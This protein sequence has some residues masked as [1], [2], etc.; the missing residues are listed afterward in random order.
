MRDKIRFDRSYGMRMSWAHLKSAVI[1]VTNIGVS[2]MLFGQNTPANLQELTHK[3]DQALRANNLAEAEQEY[4]Q[5]LA[6]DPRNSQAWTG[7]GILLYGSGR[8][9]DAGKAL[10]KALDI[11]PASQRAELFLGLSY[12]YLHRCSTAKPILSKY[13]ESEPVGKLQ[14]LTGLALLGCSSGGTDPLPALQ[15]AERLKQLY[16]GDA[17]VLFESAELYTRLWNQSAGELLAKHPDSDRVHQLAG[18]VYEAQNNYDQA[19]R[20]YFLALADN[21]KLLQMHY[22]IGQLYLKQGSPDADEKAMAEFRQENA[23]NPASAVSN[24]AMAEIER[25]KHMLDQAKSLYELAIRLDPDLTEAKVGLA[26]TLLGQ[27]EIDGASRILRALIAEHPENASAHYALML[28]YREQGNMPEANK[29]MSTFRKLQ[30]ANADDFK[31]K[32][33]ALLNA[34]PENKETL[35]K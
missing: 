10:Q 25:H 6:Q 35:Q 12:S 9:E 1:V 8:A 23:I 3:I 21:P 30:T 34:K 13:F 11:D 27:H 14:R 16:P 5:M 19:I 33:N 18:E 2:A 7:L 17:D 26:Q 31:S 20:E 22:R 24:L 4:R 15:A 29:E 32:L 28:T